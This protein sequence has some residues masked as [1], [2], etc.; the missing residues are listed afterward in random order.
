MSVEIGRSMVAQHWNG[1]RRAWKCA[2]ID[3]GNGGHISVTK[4]PL[5]YAFHA[6]AFYLNGTAK[7]IVN[8][9]C[10]HQKRKTVSKMV[11]EGSWL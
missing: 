4:G 8:S 7:H 5:D 10:G 6:G 2:R 11:L 3:G 9:I 1:D